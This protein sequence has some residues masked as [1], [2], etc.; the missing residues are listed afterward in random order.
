M[1]VH[2]PCPSRDRSARIGSFEVEIETAWARL[3]E[4]GPG[5]TRAA[6]LSP[7]TGLIVLR[8]PAATEYP[9]EIGTYC[10]SVTLAH[11]REDC[12]HTLERARP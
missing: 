2:R 11:F 3:A 8:P 6:C 12:F 7:Q 9:G 1:N 10:S 5:A 4:L